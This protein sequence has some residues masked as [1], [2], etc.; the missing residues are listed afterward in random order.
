MPADE[1]ENIVGRGVRAHLNGRTIWV[2][3]LSLLQE[4]GLSLSHEWGTQI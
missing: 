2:G 3:G 1:I 4:Q